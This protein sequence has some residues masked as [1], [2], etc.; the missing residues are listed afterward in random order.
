MKLSKYK[1]IEYCNLIVEIGNELDKAVEETADR[2]GVSVDKE[3]IDIDGTIMES[4]EKLLVP[5]YEMLTDCANSTFVKTVCEY[6]GI[7]CAAGK[8]SMMDYIHTFN[9]CNRN[10]FTTLMK[11]FES[12]CDF[13][14][15]VQSF[16]EID[17]KLFDVAN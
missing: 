5:L 9:A 13:Y 15:L 3:L 1:F 6:H 10:L 4:I 17:S 12:H 2:I 8:D 14:N 11:D 16:E 7:F